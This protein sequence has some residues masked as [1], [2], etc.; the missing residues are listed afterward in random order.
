[1]YDMPT[2]KIAIYL[3]TVEIVKASK[4]CVFADVKILARRCGPRSTAQ[5]VHGRIS[6]RTGAV[7]PEIRAGSSLRDRNR[8]LNS[9]HAKCRYNKEVR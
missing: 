9:D 3:L 4:S 7:Q 5:A 2:L 8:K 1:M 6:T